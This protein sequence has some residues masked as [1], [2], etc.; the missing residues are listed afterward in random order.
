MEQRRELR[1]VDGVYTLYVANIPFDIQIN[2]LSRLFREF[3]WVAGFSVPKNHKGGIKGFAFV[4]YKSYDS[5]MNAL[6]RIPEVSL[7]GRRLACRPSSS[8]S[9][10]HVTQRNRPHHESRTEDTPEQQKSR[11]FELTSEYSDYEEIQFTKRIDE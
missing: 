9:T 2:E 8:D 10:P 3:G 5:A 6:N 1:C 4:S 7:M 11:R